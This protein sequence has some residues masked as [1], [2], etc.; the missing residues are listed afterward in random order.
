MNLAADPTGNCPD[1]EM[2]LL[3]EEDWSD[4][5][6]DLLREED[7]S[8]LEMDL[9][10][11]EDWC[12]VRGLERSEVKPEGAENSLSSSSAI[13]STGKPSTSRLDVLDLVTREGE[14]Q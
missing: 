9:L 5:E 13:I 8:D 11:E 6:M 4:L 2:D 14:R 3:R 1:I 10:R 7:W 12:R